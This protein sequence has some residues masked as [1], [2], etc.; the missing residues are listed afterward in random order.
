M[1]VLLMRPQ[2]PPMTTA[3]IERLIVP[4]DGSSRAEAAI[5]TATEL[6]RHLDAPLQLTTVI[7]P[8]RDFPESPAY[9]GAL[10]AGFREEIESGLVAETREYL[11][12][13]AGDVIRAGV[14]VRY[15]VRYGSTAQTLIDEGRPGDL[16][17][18]TSHGRSAQPHWQLGGIATRL[19]RDGNVPIIRVRP[20]QPAGI[21]AG[22][23]GF[24][25]A[26]RNLLSV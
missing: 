4:L 26:R 8:N 22:T 21:R 15:D 23:V 24:D 25:P 20:Q 5:W 7:D 17:V 12:R 6:S 1:P 11:R 14:A 3:K 16:I 9:A 13:V 2:D 19:L 18:M 10:A